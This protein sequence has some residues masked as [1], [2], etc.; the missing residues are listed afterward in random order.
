[1][2]DAAAEVAGAKES[3]RAGLETYLHTHIPLSRHLAAAVVEAS[4]DRVRLRA[5]LAA[6]VNH[7]GTAFGG[8]ISALAILAAWSLLHLRLASVRGRWRIVIQRNSVEYL[9]PAADDFEAECSA[10]GGAGWSAFLEMLE[11]RG[12]GR[13]DLTAHVVSA[14]RLAATFAGRYVAIRQPDRVTPR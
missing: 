14:G 7:R 6:N 9:S 8:S 2:S 1:M 11:Q 5:P 12:R 13:L 3:A 4:R 10:P